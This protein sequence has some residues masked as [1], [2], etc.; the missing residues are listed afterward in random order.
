[1]FNKKICKNCGKKINDNYEFCPYC[2][3]RIKDNIKNSENWGILGEND[4]YNEE[5]D[6]LSKSFF[7]SLNNGLLG[8]MVNNAMKMLEKEFQKANEKELEKTNFQLY[9]NGKKVN[10]SNI[11][12]TQKEN[13]EIPLDKIPKKS[14]SKEKIKRLAYLPKEEPLSSMKRVSDDL[15][16]EI[17]I[18]GVDSINDIIISKLEN[19]IEIKAL[20]KDKVYSKL[21]PINLPIKK[22]NLFKNKLIL[23]LDAK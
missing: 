4:N 18:P 1:M 15:I 3:A 2:G 6:I 9:I 20:A 21:L 22:Y 16:Y 17:N 8:K 11:K 5:P 23:H 19:S 14:L 12:V 13:K 10:P 7:N